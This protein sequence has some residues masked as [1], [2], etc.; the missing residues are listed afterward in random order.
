ME[1][2]YDIAQRSDASQSVDPRNEEPAHFEYLYGVTV[3]VDPGATA[4][5]S[6][7]HFV[8]MGGT[9][10]LGAKPRASKKRRNAGDIRVRVTCTMI[11]S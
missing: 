2:G 8:C 11:A 3:H 7:F 10:K 9:W 5:L 4:P 1:T 6:I